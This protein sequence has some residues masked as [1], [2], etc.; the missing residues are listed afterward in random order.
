MVVRLFHDWDS[1]C[2]FKVRMCLSEKAIGWES[3]RVD[4]VRF[5]HLQP[6]YLAINPNGVVPTLEHDGFVVRESSVINEYLDEAFPGVRVIPADPSERA[7]MRQWVK[8]QDD[9]LYHAQRP[10]T[11]QLLVK[12]LLTSLSK[13][14]LEALVENHP[15]PQRARHFLDWA[16]GPID[17]AVVAEARQKLSTVIA[18][19]DHRLRDVDWLAGSQ[20]SLAECAYAPFIYRLRRL[21]FADLWQDQPRVAS[22]TQRV[23]ERPSFAAASPPPEYAMATGTASTS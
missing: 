15:E 1:V 12:P 18:R 17:H 19:L 4:L 2:S 10:A 3:R 16:T 13:Q 21:G 5:E 22:W 23:S 20:F 11:F 6:Q 8:Y 9:V 7:S 14:E